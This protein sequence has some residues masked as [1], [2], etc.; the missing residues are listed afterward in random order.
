VI[1]AT[2]EDGDVLAYKT[3]APG[4]MLS[5]PLSTIYVAFVD[6]LTLVVPPSIKIGEAAASGVKSNG[7]ST[8]S[9]IMGIRGLLSQRD[10]RVEG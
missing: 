6:V 1:D 5:V 7:T 3:S 4:R 2:L 9:R 8:T 10:A